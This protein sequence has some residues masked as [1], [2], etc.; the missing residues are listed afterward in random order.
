MGE[1]NC[2]E[3]RPLRS[4]SCNKK[5]KL[6][7]PSNS[8]QVSGRD[9]QRSGT[10]QKRGRGYF[11]FYFLIMFQRRRLVINLIAV[12]FCFFFAPNVRCL[13]RDLQGE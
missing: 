4:V 6:F 7:I 2:P 9:P 3:L 8:P 12:F 1:D 5:P 11:L 13:C 10:V